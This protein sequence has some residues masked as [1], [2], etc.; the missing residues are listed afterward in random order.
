M[1]NMDPEALYRQLGLLAQ[2]LPD[3]RSTGP[4]GTET[5][6][7]LA[8]AHA[9][10]REL[11]DISDQVEFKSAWD[12]ASKYANDPEDRRERAG[13][14]TNILYRALAIAELR[15][16][17]SSQGAFIPA[18][19]EFDAFAGVAKVLN[20]ATREIL[21]VDPYMD[22]KTLT[23]FA[24]TAPEG[25]SIRLL[26]DNADHKPSLIPAVQRWAKQ[27]LTHPL[28]ARLA[29][30]K[31]LHDR[32]IVLDRKV[33]HTLTQSLNALAARSPATIVRI[34][35]PEVARKK[36]ETYENFWNAATV[37]K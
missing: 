18:G 14:I 19:N 23:D 27:H 35:D 21:I 5:L 36:I 37:I 8:R 20:N 26:A 24:P 12:M 33:A 31:T 6:T 25:V 4:Y 1:K 11:D 29:P 9:L 7:W 10:L 13:K 28:E 22:A 32:L 17:V 15:A 16:P 3:L 30:D 2:T 34:D